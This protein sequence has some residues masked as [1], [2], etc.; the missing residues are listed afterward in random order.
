MKDTVT[1][2]KDDEN[3]AQQSFCKITFRVF[4]GVQIDQLNYVVTCIASLEWAV[5]AELFFSFFWL[6]DLGGSFFQNDEQGNKK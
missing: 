6:V 4:L 3:P 1:I 2:L 5:V